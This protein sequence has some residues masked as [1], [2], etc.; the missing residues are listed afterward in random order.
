MSLIFSTMRRIWSGEEGRYPLYNIERTG[1][2][3]YGI[4]V[5]LAG[6]APKDMEGVNCC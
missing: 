2:D 4:A 6:F 5:A 3:R 1:E